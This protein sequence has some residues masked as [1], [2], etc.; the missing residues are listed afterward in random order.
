MKS[1]CSRGPEGLKFGKKWPEN[2]NIRLHP[3]LKT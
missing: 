1:G 2:R 3:E